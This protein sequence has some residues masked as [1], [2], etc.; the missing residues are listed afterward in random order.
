M[1]IKK[2]IFILTDTLRAKNVGLY[3]KK[4]STTPNIDQLKRNSWV[5]LNAYASATSTDP[6]VT[7]IM[8]GNYPVNNGLINHGKYVRK[9]E[10]DNISTLP[11]LSEILRKSGFKTAAVDWM[12][13]WHK[14]GYN[15]YSGSLNEDFGSDISV[16]YKFPFPFL[17]RILDKISV[18]IFHREFFIRAYYALHSNPKFPYD[19]ADLIVNKA[20]QILEKTQ[21][22]NL[23]LYLHF[24][25]AHVPHTR[26]KG[27]VSYLTDKVED[28]YNAEIFFL[29]QEL[30]RLFDYLKKKKLWEETLIVLT[31]DHGENFGRKGIPFNHENLY[32]DVVKIPLIFCHH[33]F[34]PTIIKDLTQHVDIFPTL[35]SLLNIPVPKTDGN[36]LDPLITKN[37]LLKRKFVYFEDITHRKTKLLPIYRRK[38]LYDG[39]YKYI[40]T[41][42]ATE[43]KLGNIMT[44]EDTKVT[45]LEVYNLKQDPEEKNNLAL[46][47]KHKTHHLDMLL[48]RH[49]YS[50]NQKRFY[51]NSTSRLKLEKTKKIIE[52]AFK[53]YQAEELAIAW[54]GGKDTTVMMHIIRSIYGKIPCRVFFND[55]TLEFK[56]TY[57]FIRL[58]KKLWNLDLITIRHSQKELNEYHN[59][60]DTGRRKELARLMKITA[61]KT[62]LEKY[63]FKGFMLGIRKDENPARLKEKF[64]S[65]R[66]DHIRI[67]PLLQWN[68]KDIWNYIFCFGVP[69]NSLYDK[70]YRS[71][72]EEEYTSKVKG[73]AGE[74][75]GRDQEKE[76]LME[77]LRRLGYW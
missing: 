19:P 31:A 34:K 24:W 35:L 10:E 30:G 20:L 37:K 72:G 33:D 18:K 23:F 57:D 75:A 5:F 2:V 14:R 21:E 64:F 1:A 69:Y 25:D 7:S 29:D 12:G 53:N 40:K 54:K 41:F 13:R 43:D 26:P 74:R 6:S 51:R 56:E 42:C 68:E 8:T 11:Y 66:V 50:L 73:D 47:L 61:I 28:T 32:E 17:L 70:G 39:T 16:A 55:T 22:K 71:I 49:L 67:H 3:G 38:G 44:S 48:N 52:I 65:K 46:S 45:G 15:Y 77:K 62:A 36:N 58:I 60:R 4:P 63:Q 27:I 9:S 59:T 76:K